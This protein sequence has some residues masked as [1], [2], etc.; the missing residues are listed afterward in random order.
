MEKNKIWFPVFVQIFATHINTEKKKEEISLS[1]TH[2]LMSSS[3]VTLIS[4]L[5]EA[6]GAYVTFSA[7]KSLFVMNPSISFYFFRII[8]CEENFGVK[9]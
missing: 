2:H 8:F 5:H 9:S 3:G 4:A 7:F 6:Y 1:H